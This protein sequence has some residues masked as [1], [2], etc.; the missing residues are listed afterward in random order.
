MKFIEI[1]RN[2]LFAIA[3]VIII[4]FV[5]CLIFRIKPGVVISGSMEPAIHV[6]SLAFINE[7]D[8]EPEVGDAIAFQNGDNIVTHRVVEKVSDGYKTK[9]DSNENADPWTVDRAN[10]VGKIIFSIPL[11]GYVFNFIT[12][13]KGIIIC[14]ALIIC[15]VL[16]SFL[17]I[18]PK[19]NNEQ[20]TK[21]DY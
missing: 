17:T 14:V 5:A 8:K 16:T 20:E 6:G 3:I 15:L 4:G 1:V 7:K 12:T 18:K 11:L 21:Q 2:I 13:T 9:G 10:V 19:E